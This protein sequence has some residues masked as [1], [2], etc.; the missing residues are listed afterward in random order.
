MDTGM[1]CWQL[2]HGVQIQVERVPGGRPQEHGQDVDYVVLM[3]TP[4]FTGAIQPNGW[5]QLRHES[6]L[7]KHLAD[8]KEV[9]HQ[10]LQ[11]LACV[12]QALHWQWGGHRQRS[13]DILCT[14]GVF[15]LFTVILLLLTAGAAL[16]TAAV[17][18]K[19]RFP[20]QSTDLSEQHKGSYNGLK[21]PL[22]QHRREH[23]FLRTPALLNLLRQPSHLLMQVFFTLLH[24]LDHRHIYL[25]IKLQPTPDSQHSYDKDDCHNHGLDEV[26]E[27]GAQPGWVGRST[28]LGKWCRRCMDLE[29]SGRGG[30]AAGRE[31]GQ[32]L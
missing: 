14:I 24:V 29:V 12:R 5:V 32:G 26:E 7:A 21:W 3:D 23:G 4:G 13:N 2:H 17:R 22:L 19:L 20:H 6:T 18:H 11:H 30:E 15:L 25:M 28:G 10:L 8:T 16:L 1:P 9:S 31:Q 27:K